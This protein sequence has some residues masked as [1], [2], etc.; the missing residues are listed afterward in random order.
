MKLITDTDELTAYCARLAQAP[1]ITVDTEFLREKTFWPRLCLVQVAGPE[2]ELIIDPLAPGMD[3]SPLYDLMANTAVLKVFH[4]ARQDVEIFHH[5][6]GV[7]PRPMFDTQ[8]AAMVCGFGDSV[9]YDTLARKISKVHID[10]SSRFSDWSVRPLS[11]RQ[12]KY[13]MQ[14]VTHLRGVYEWLAREL[15]KNGREAWLMEEM[16]ILTDPKTYLTEPRE[17][18][19][20]IKT[21][22]GNRRFL[23]V[24]RE[25]TAWRETEAQTRDLPRN[26]VIRDEALLEIAAHPPHTIAEMGKMRSVTAGFA[27]GKLGQS[28]LAAIRLGA[29]MPEADLPPLPDRDPP[30]KSTGGTVELLKVLLKI[31]CEQAGVA[32]KLVANSADLDRIAADDEA[33]VP[34]MHGW[35]RELFGLAALQLKHGKLAITM[36]GNKIVLAPLAGEP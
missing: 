8:V 29:E 33:D 13:A 18:W 14:D 19:L 16:A 2:D 3:L 10:K 21:R 28:L 23:G 24:L 12:L 11:E 30:G 6:G 27:E 22:G 34:A 4:A 20:R 15:R 5:D 9:G 26:R 7:M 17:A 1:Y 36:K 25:I 32:S 35:R 31:K